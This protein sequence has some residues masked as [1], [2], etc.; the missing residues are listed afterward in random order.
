MPG[1]LVYKSFLSLVDEATVLM[2]GVGYMDWQASLHLD[3]HITDLELGETMHAGAV[4]ELLGH[5]LNAEGQLLFGGY[6]DRLTSFTLLSPAKRST[7]IVQSS[8]IPVPAIEAALTAI[9]RDGGS[10]E[11]C[12][13]SDTS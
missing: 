4:G 7:M 2:M 8:S 13:E 9:R 1:Q 10:G 11:R 6:H 3:G 5:G 12:G